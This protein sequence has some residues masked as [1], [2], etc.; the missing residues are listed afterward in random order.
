MPLPNFLPQLQEGGQLVSALMGQNALTNSSLENTIKKAQAQYAPYQAYG[1]AYLTNQEA[2]WTPYKYQMQAASNPLLWM[3][4]QS[5]PALMKQLQQMMASPNMPQGQGGINIPL[6]N[7][8]SNDSQNPLAML[9]NMIFGN[10]SNQ[11]LSGQSQMPQQNAIQ[12]N[13]SGNMRVPSSN[14]VNNQPSIGGN[15]NAQSMNQSSASN[16]NQGASPFAAPTSSAGQVGAHYTTP[17]QQL[18]IKGGIPLTTKS[19]QVVSPPTE[20]TVAQIQQSYLSLQNAIPLLDSI[21]ERGERILGS[22]QLKNVNIS[23]LINSLDQYGISPPK[24]VI[25][26]IAKTFGVDPEAIDEFGK[27]NADRKKASEALMGGLNL[28]SNQMSLEDVHS[29]VDP[30]SGESGKG[31][32]ERIRQEKKYLTDT[33]LPQYTKMLSTGQPISGQGAPEA[34]KKSNN[35][36]SPKLGKDEWIVYSPQGKPVGIGTTENTNRLLKDHKG[37]YR[38]KS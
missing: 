20:G 29:L 12:G 28:P 34:N 22:G 32:A 37:Y 33:R 5:N 11:V 2:Q 19:G 17:F 4:A 21:A 30:V 18:P 8:Q 7:Q 25:N 36:T 15:D 14:E 26:T 38:K 27:W 9:A 10:R 1:N 16:D 23:S 13:T 3:A 35:Q 6:P 31:Y 24:A